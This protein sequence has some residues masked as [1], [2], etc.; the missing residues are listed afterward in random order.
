MLSE[1]TLGPWAKGLG[2]H[3]A[4]QNK[5]IYALNARF[6]GRFAPSHLPR[7]RQVPGE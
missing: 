2:E 6:F 4:P 1:A 3:L 7:N 5:R